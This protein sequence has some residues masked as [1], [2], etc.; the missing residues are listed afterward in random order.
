MHV[1]NTDD[2][3]PVDAPDVWLAL[4]QLADELNRALGPDT[5]YCVVIV[6]HGDTSHLQT[7]GN[8]SEARAREVLGAAQCGPIGA[9]N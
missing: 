2:D 8:M 4:A 6:Q 5:E 7:C 3:G 1:E 9:A